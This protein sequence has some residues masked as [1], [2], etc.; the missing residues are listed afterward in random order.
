MGN[1]WSAPGVWNPGELWTPQELLPVFF[2]GLYIVFLVWK[3]CYALAIFVVSLPI[4]TNY[5]YVFYTFLFLLFFIS[6]R[7]KG[8]V[9]Q[10]PRPGAQ[11]ARVRPPQEAGPCQRTR[12]SPW[13]CRARLVIS[14]FSFYFNFLILA[15]QLK[16]VII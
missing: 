11:E 15:M 10:T 7:Q 8:G 2:S 4:F 9:S 13:S 14:L 3:S 1:A 12:R 5:F 16:I 6:A